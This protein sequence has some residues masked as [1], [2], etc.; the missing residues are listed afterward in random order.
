MQIIK[1]MRW[2]PWRS[3]CYPTNHHHISEAMS[4]A[5]NLKPL[6]VFFYNTWMARCVAYLGK[7]RHQGPLWEESKLAEAVWC[8]EQCSAGKPC[9]CYSDI[10]H[11]PKHCCRPCAIFHGN[12]IPWWL[13][14]FSA[15]WCTLP[16]S[17]NGSGMIWGAK[18]CIWDVDFGSKFLSSQ[19][20]WAS[21]GCA[22]QTTHLERMCC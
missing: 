2:L 15:E 21:V 7:T 5:M 9:W 8:L 4:K 14:P 18:Q 3:F 19:S 1:Q 13:W 20:T 16:Q 12:G 6:L 11:L 10:Y 22:G 17:K